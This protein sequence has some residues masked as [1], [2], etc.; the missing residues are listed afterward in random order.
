MLPG[1]LL[2]N[3]LSGSREGYYQLN[4]FAMALAVPVFLEQRCGVFPIGKTFRN[5]QIAKKQ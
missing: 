2:T 4:S 1:K 5:L 3:I